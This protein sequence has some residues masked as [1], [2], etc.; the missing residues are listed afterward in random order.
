MK[1]KDYFQFKW[2]DE[3]QVGDVFKFS[4]IIDN[5]IPTKFYTVYQ[6]DENKT[7]FNATY[8]KELNRMEFANDLDRE[9]MIFPY[10]KNKHKTT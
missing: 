5:D 6:K 9:I 10:R 7:R 1:H 4:P 2:F 8:G 3:L